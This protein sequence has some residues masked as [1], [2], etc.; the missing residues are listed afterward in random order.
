MMKLQIYT[1]GASRGNPGPSAYGFI[2]I[3]KGA[4]NPFLE[5]NQFLGPST[6]NVAEYTAIIHALKEAKN[7]SSGYIEVFSDSQLAVKQLTGEWQ[8]KKDHLIP[9]VAEIKEIIKAFEQV[10]FYH[11]RRT[12]KFI[13][14][15]DR[16]CN[17]ALDENL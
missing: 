5:R 10:R 15:A 13:K 14:I 3:E 17:E 9:L 12:N 11:V 2:L 6:N 1:D 7:H 16:L 8:I 4:K